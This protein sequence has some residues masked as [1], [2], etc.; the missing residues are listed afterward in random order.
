MKTIIPILLVVLLSAFP[1]R[2]ETLPEA[3]ATAYNSNPLIAAERAKLRGTDEQVSLS[4]SGYRPSVEAEALLGGT[5]SDTSLFKDNKRTP[6]SVALKAMQPLYAGGR[7]DAK[8]EETENLVFAARANLFQLEQNTLYDAA[9]AYLAVIRNSA[10]VQLT[11]NNE[12]VLQKQLGA[13]ENR[14][15]V[16]EITRTDVDQAISRL[17]RAEAARM[18]AE[19]R[20]ASSIATY[21]KY[22]GSQPQSLMPPQ[23]PL[24]AF[25]NVEQAV[26]MAIRNHP[27]VKAAEFLVNRARA[28]VKGAKGS[29][30]PEV[31]LLASV[32]RSW[33]Q[34]AAFPDRTDSASLMAQI[35]IPLY[36]T[37]SDYSKIRAAQQSVAEKSS[38][39][40]AIRRAV[41]EGMVQAWF[42]LKTTLSVIKAR[43]SGVAAA[44][45]ALNGVRE[46]SLAG[47]R[48]TLDV[49]D[50][51]QE[52]LDAKV[53]MTEAAH[54]RDLAILRMRAASGHMT[55][56]ALRLPVSLYDPT[57]NYEK[58]RDQWFGFDSDVAESK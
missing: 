1:L 42:H 16:G 12:A 8:I 55:A 26:D 45:S 19:G 33:D 48:T 28:S 57:A 13:V 34:S 31:N 58:V 10:I 51:E 18:E 56:E 43:Q 40:E 41:R 14:F 52:L 2:A 44:E 3:L 29:L 54:D 38:E 37:G 25:E 7:N 47:T 53:K 35:K 15:D 49:L 46:E 23:L 4:M 30:W 5:Y 22:M 20:L 17:K 6:A 32:E 9:G 21:V 39:V 11:R 50:A 27:S 24:P 36:K